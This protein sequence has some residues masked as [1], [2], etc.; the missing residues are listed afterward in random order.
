MVCDF[1]D[2]V[3]FRF[4]IGRKYYLKDRVKGDPAFAERNFSADRPAFVKTSARQVNA[5]LR[6][7]NVSMTRGDIDTLTDS[8]LFSATSVKS[9][10]INSSQSF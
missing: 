8:F 10:D 1:Q 3:N 7:Y 2:I 4:N 9:A 5:D 6:R